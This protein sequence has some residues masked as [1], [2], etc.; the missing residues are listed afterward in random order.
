[1]YVIYLD[2]LFLM[3]L[4]IDMMIFYI[5]TMILN[6]S[7]SKFKIF[8]AS[9]IAASINCALVCIPIL[10]NIPQL[11]Y[12]C[13]IPTISILYLYRPLTIKI[14]FKIYLICM[15]VACI[16]GGATFTIWFMFRGDDSF[17]MIS[18][19]YVIG[20]ALVI[21]CFVYLSFTSIRRR[22]ILPFFEYEI[23]IKHVNQ[24]VCVKS[25]LDT[26]NC[27]YTP[28]GHKPVIVVTYDT[29]KTI[30]TYQQSLLLEEYQDNIL[31]VIS[32]DDFKSSYL[33]P[34]ESVGCQIGM[35]LGMEVEEV[36]ICKNHFKKKVKGCIVAISF[37]HLFKDQSYQAL[38]HPDF[39]L[40]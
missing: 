8:I 23:T 21:T 34:F 26:G 37:N 31:E 7:I 33:I 10:Q 32:Y 35:L 11:V 9:L 2:I 1:M 17:Y 3:N 15:G 29:L 18:S 27:L 30:F 36:S 40:N 19:I 14:F 38:L 12:A 5:S 24:E 16:I 20:I 4:F 22:M 6:Q 13:L 28:I 25:L 39:I